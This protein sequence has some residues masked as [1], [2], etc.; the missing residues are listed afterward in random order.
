MYREKNRCSKYI[1]F[2][3]LI[4]REESASYNFRQITLNNIIDVFSTWVLID[5]IKSK[6]KLLFKIFI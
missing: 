3:I 6:L 2:F 5:V 4:F 1:V